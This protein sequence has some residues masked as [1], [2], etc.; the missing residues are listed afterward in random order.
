MLKVYSQAEYDALPD[1]KRGDLN[2]DGDV[3]VADLVAMVNIILGK[4]GKMSEADLNGDGDVTVGDY[5]ILVNIVLGKN[6]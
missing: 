4:K 6:N 3:S 2:G 1:G 5:V